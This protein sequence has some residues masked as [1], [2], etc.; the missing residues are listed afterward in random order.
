MDKLLCDYGCGLPA[1]FH[2]ANGGNG[3]SKSPNSCTAKRSKDSAA[4][5]GKFCGVQF[6]NTAGY[7]EADKTPWNKGKKFKGDSRWIENG[8]KAIETRILR[9]FPVGCANTE[10]AEEKRRRNISK[11]MKG[12]PKAGGM[13]EGSGRGV[14]QWYNSHIAGKV[15]VRSSYELEY[16]KWL[17]ANGVRWKANTTGFSY[18]W[19]GD[20]RT[21]YPDFF[22]IDENCYVEI[23]GYKTEQDLAKWEEFPFPLKVLMGTDL[24]N[25]GLKVVL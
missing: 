22:L 12:N 4:K 8:K 19:N 1:L 10:E 18:A 16:V 11:A 7:A 15:Y 9:G 21:Y 5:K 3:C 20:K 17:D 24:K 2:Y 6:H 23:K 13:R 25:M 14:K